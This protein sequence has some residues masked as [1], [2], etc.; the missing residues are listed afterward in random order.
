MPRVVCN[1]A[2]CGDLL[3]RKI[4]MAVRSD[5]SPDGRWLIATDWQTGDLEI[6]DIATGQLR[7]LLAKTGG[8]RADN[9]SYAELPVFSAD[10]RRIAYQSD[11][12]VTGRNSTPFQLRV[13]ANQPGSQSR[14]LLHNPEFTSFVPLN[15][16]PDSKRIM[17]SIEMQIAHGFLPGYRSQAAPCSASK[18]LGGACTRVEKMTGPGFLRMAATLHIRR[19]RSNFRVHRRLR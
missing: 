3:G 7:R 13:M 17:V 6:R 1:A 19:W 8:F 14:V 4:N 12:G 16:S 5:L 9:Q 2:N 11:S 18:M 10:L 15:W